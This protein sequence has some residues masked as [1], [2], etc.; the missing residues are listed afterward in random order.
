MEVE[1]I[2]EVLLTNFQRTHII[3]LFKTCFEVYPKDRLYYNQLP[4]FRFLAWEKPQLIG[5][6]GV[7][8]RVISAAGKQYSVFGI[9]DLCVDQKYWK[10]QVA[11]KLLKE[12]E[13][14]ARSGGVDFL[15]LTT[16]G[17]AVYKR[18][19]FM[20]VDNLCRWVLINNNQTYGVVERSIGE[21]FMV[22]EIS[23]TEWPKEHLIDLMG[24]M[25]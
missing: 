1:R 15:V 8:H 11:S 19:G 3:K 4:H 22:K 18:N 20:H 2:E 13:N 21:G 16:S 5:H 24:H 7:N 12:C 6:L 25:F 9:V 17:D 10:R 23:D 14:L